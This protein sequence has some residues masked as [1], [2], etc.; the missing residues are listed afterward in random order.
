MPTVVHPKTLDTYYAALA[1]YRAQGVGHESALFRPFCKQYLYFDRLLVEQAYQ[2][3]HFFPTPE[4]EAEN[5]V[6]WLK[7]GSEVPM[8]ALM[9]NVIPDLMP[10]GGTQCFPFYTYAED[11]SNRRENVT[12][13]ALGQF[14]ARYGAE[15]SK[16]DIF[17]YV[18]AVLHHPQYRERYAE[19]LKRELPR[20]PYVAD[21]S[22]AE[23]PSLPSSQL[24]HKAG[25]ETPPY[26]GAFWRM[27]EIGRQLATLHLN[28]EQVAE[29]L[30][31]GI[32]NK[33]VPFS[34]KVTRLATFGEN[35]KHPNERTN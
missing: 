10:Q 8:F 3:P 18:Y 29:Y 16:R 27:V 7:V 31:K 6:I 24:Q 26:K 19:N 11:G 17:H 14:Q 30:L 22:R 2:F 35:R 15:V 5:T 23:S 1:I 32:E 20:I 21:E 33:G 34:W 25:T 28:Y 13:W 4:N 12:D 9:T